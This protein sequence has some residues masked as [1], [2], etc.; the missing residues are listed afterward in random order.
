MQQGADT[1][2]LLSLT[3]F[4]LYADYGTTGQLTLT[5]YTKLGGLRQVVQTEI[6][7]F[8][9][10]TPPNGA[11]NWSCCGRRS[12]R[13]WPPSTPTPTPRCAGGPAGPTCPRTA[14]P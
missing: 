9:A 2:P 14:G 6:D 12:F 13:G 5:E 11:T 8:L 7:S 4:R 3:L 1:L 10:A